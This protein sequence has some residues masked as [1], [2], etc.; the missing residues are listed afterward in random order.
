MLLNVHVHMQS[1]SSFSLSNCSNLSLPFPVDHRKQVYFTF[2]LKGNL[3]G[4]KTAHLV[5][6]VLLF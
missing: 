6:D 5:C 3:T 2:A 4:V 1:T